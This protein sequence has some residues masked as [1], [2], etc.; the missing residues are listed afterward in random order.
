MLTTT[1]AHSTTFVVSKQED[2]EILIIGLRTPDT[3]LRTPDSGLSLY[4]QLIIDAPDSVGAASD[5][6]GLSD[7]LL[8]ADLA[9]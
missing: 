1:E 4:N 3:G 6:S 2:L 9:F 7:L 8:V 5:F